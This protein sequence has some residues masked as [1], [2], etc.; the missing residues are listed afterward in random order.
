MYIS[1]CLHKASGLLTLVRPTTMSSCDRGKYRYDDMETMT[2]VLT[3]VSSESGR[4][5]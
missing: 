4:S 3:E 5:I 1:A 2:F